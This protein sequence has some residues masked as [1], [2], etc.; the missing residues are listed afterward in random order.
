M[1]LSSGEIKMRWLD[2][3]TN[4]MDMN[5]SK[6][7]KVVK[8]REAWLA[9]VHGVAESQTRL[10]DRTTATRTRPLACAHER[11]SCRAQ[12]V[13]N[14]HAMQEHRRCGFDPQVGKI[15]LEEEMATH[16]TI[17]AWK[18]P[19]AEEPDGL[20]SKGWQRVGHSEPLSTHR[21][22]YLRGSYL[23]K[24]HTD[25]SATV[26]PRWQHSVSCKAYI[27]KYLYSDCIFVSVSWV[28]DLPILDIRILSAWFKVWN[29]IMAGKK[30]RINETNLW[31]KLHTNYYANYL[32]INVQ[33]CGIGR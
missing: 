19:W 17:L 29:L 8:D 11:A 16:S 33:L 22:L 9:A 6:L 4:S 5:L 10:S 13:K 1:E 27:E 24:C 3:V 30:S 18:I 26:W 2:G 12:G 15:P 14:S 21:H 31:N 7:L 23:V 28:I 32:S 25:I 20:Q